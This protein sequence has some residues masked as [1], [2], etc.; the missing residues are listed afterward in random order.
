MSGRVQRLPHLI[1]LSFPGSLGRS[2]TSAG[3]SHQVK[4]LWAT[5]SWKDAR[6][7]LFTQ[8]TLAVHL[9][10]ARPVPGS[11]PGRDT[12]VCCQTVQAL[13]QN[14]SST[15]GNFNKR[16]AV[17]WGEGQAC[18]E[19]G[20]CLQPASALVVDRPEASSQVLSDGQGQ[21]QRMIV[22]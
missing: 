7:H 9:L 22:Q 1:G 4:F 8:Q 10:C 19:R 3:A 16:E 14:V 5:A 18:V 2:V 12:S 6:L 15:P 21:V 11:F 20:R 17:G 13:V